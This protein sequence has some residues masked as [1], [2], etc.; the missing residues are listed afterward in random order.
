M[1]KIYVFLLLIALLRSFPVNSQEVFNINSKSS[2]ILVSGTSTLHSWE[3]TSKLVTG[4]MKTV[5]EF[6]EIKIIS[7]V[8]ISCNSKSLLSDEKGLNDNAYKA[9]KADSY[10]QIKF[11]STAISGLKSSNSIFSG[12]IIGNLTIAGK[13]KKVSIPFTGKVISN[14][15]VGV[16][17][18]FGLNMSEYNIEKPTFLMGMMSTGDH[19]TL[20]FMLEFVKSVV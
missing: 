13:T 2:E 3:M 18:S 7:D 14:G 15:D 9:L 16:K 20:S 4:K 12:T 8:Q 17:A 10:P 5:I 1:K 19:I 11:V 6:P